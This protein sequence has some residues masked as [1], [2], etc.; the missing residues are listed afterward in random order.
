MQAS[1]VFALSM[2]EH[3]FTMFLSPRS[4]PDRLFCT[5]KV[6][7][8]YVLKPMTTHHSFHVTCSMNKHPTCLQDRQIPE[9]RGLVDTQAMDRTVPLFSSHAY[10][11]N[12]R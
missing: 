7:H 3:T 11:Q 6:L 1:R 10:Q 5:V 4:L 2:Y 8:R 12:F 9:G